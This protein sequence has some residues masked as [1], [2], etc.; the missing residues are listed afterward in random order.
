MALNRATGQ[1]E[2]PDHKATITILD[3]PLQLYPQIEQM[4]F[5]DNA[6]V[7][8]RESF[9]FAS[10]IGFFATVRLTANGV[11]YRK[12][13]LLASSA[14]APVSDLAT[15]VSIQVPEDQTAAYPEDAVRKALASVSFRP[16]PLDERLSLLPFV[17]TDL[18]GFEIGQISPAGVILGD[19]QRPNAL[20]RLF[21]SVGG[22]VPNRPEDRD[23]F[24]RDLLRTIPVRDLV[25]LSAEPMRIRGTPGFEIQAEAR[26][27]SGA[28]MRLVEWLRF[29]GGRF[30]AV[31]AGA[32]KNDWTNAYPRFRAVRDGIEP[33]Q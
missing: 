10:G 25:V 23:R 30:L 22:D 3:L 14:A 18:A 6:T 8:K 20:P 26:D 31:V 13:L 7:L 1:F 2:D 16:P 27:P 5:A 33:R 24:A 28:E 21:V 11:T 9:P 15:L 4:V 29:G 32:D 12:W 19:P 17:I